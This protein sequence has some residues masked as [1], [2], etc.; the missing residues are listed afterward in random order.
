MVI[1]AASLHLTTGRMVNEED[2]DMRS[3]GK[4]EPR[5][6][7]NSESTFSSYPQLNDGR[8]RRERSGRRGMQTRSFLK[9]AV[10]IWLRRER[11]KQIEKQLVCNKPLC[12]AVLLILCDDTPALLSE[13]KHTF[14]NIHAQVSS[15][16]WCSITMQQMFH[17]S[18][19]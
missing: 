5:K 11:K 14:Q 12:L 13:N 2:A 16:C 7:K 18:G 6:P 1:A 15:T 9:V 17:Q 8:R 19:S 4:I 10:R 3:I